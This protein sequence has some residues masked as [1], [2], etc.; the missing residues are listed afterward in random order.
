MCG[1]GH[2]DGDNDAGSGISSSGR[3]IPTFDEQQRLNNHIHAKQA[4]AQNTDFN[5]HHTS[6]RVPRCLRRAQDAIA[7][8]HLADA[9]ERLTTR[10]RASLSED[11]APK[12]PY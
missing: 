2:G 10:G 5:Q 8:I 12:D 11:R 1:T 6:G 7:E 3:Y 9:I 4:F